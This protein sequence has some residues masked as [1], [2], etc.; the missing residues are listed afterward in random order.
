MRFRPAAT[1]NNPATVAA[2]KNRQGTRC[3]TVWQRT[4]KSLINYTCVGVQFQCQK[5]Q[6]KPE[7]LR[8][9]LTCQRCVSRCPAAAY[10]SAYFSFAF[11]RRLSRAFG[12]LAAL[13]D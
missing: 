10:K 2:K 13:P 9:L 11:E 1:P 8:F 4:R 3:Q 5:N 7:V 12:T 6:G